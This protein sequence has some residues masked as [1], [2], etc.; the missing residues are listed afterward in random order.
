MIKNV[1]RQLLLADTTITGK[2]ATYQFSNLAGVE[3]EPAIFTTAVI[4]E[5]A[6]LPAIIISHTGG[7]A[8]GCRSQRGAVLGVSVQAYDDK[9]CSM[10]VLD[11][12]GFAIWECCN[13]ANL[14][15]YLSAVGYDD[16]GCIASPPHA[17]GDGE[18]YP[19]YT[20]QVQERVLKQ[21]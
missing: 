10:K 11:E 5:D 16:W 3:A 19:G 8:F 13:R 1:I 21:E 9:D 6:A 7:T 12:L 4:P 2:L 18:G 14:K 17:S 15:I 20:V